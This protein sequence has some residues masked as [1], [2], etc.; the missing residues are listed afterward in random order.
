MAVKSALY[1]TKVP[2]VT[3]SAVDGGEPELELSSDPFNHSRYYNII[4]IYHLT[5]T[6]TLSNHAYKYHHILY[7][8]IHSTSGYKF[9]NDMNEYVAALKT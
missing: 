5:R 1:S 6:V 7:D 4:H 9:G 3:V 2:V 8:F